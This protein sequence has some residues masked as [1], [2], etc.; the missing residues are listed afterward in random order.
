MEKK[1]IEKESWIGN[2]IYIQFHWNKTKSI[3]EKFNKKGR[4]RS[5]YED[6]QKS[7][8]SIYHRMTREGL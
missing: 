7:R 5:E 6:S 8:Q 4:R 3:V 2:N 1:P